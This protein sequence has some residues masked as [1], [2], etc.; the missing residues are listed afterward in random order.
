MP[1]CKKQDHKVSIKGEMLLVPFFQF[2]FIAKNV[3]VGSMN[4]LTV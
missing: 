2:S 4:I 1:A 3:T